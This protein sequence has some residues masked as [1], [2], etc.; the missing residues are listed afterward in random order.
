MPFWV[1]LGESQSHLGRD[2]TNWSCMFKHAESGVD[3]SFRPFLSLPDTGQGN[4]AEREYSFAKLS[5]R[6]RPKLSFD[7]FQSRNGAMAGFDLLPRGGS[8]K[9]AEGG[10]AGSEKVPKTDSTEDKP[11]FSAKDPI[12]T[13]PKWREDSGRSGPSPRAQQS[14]CDGFDVRV[15]VVKTDIYDNEDRPRGERIYFTTKTV[16]ELIYGDRSFDGIVALPGW[17]K[18]TKEAAGCLWIHLPANNASV[19]LQV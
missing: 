14:A 2:S 13:K 9:E 8:G 17:F 5:A 4:S 19:P 6:L 3:S 10:L 12:A 11:M 1:L 18:P 16:S 15:C 7:D